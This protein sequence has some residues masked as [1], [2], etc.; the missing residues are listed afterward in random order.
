MG[1]GL[2]KVNVVFEGDGY[3]LI[4][5][6]EHGYIRVD[7]LPSM[8]ELREYYSKQYFSKTKPGFTEDQ[9]EEIDWYKLWFEEFRFHF[10]RLLMGTGTCPPKLLEIGC[11]NGLMLLHF[12]K[13]GW[14]VAGIEPSQDISTFAARKNIRI[15]NRL[16]EEITPNDI[17][18]FDCIM[19]SGVL[20]HIRDPFNIINRC[21]LFLKKD[22]VLCVRVPNDFNPFQMA[23]IKKF[24][25]EQWWICIPDHL[26]YFNVDTLERLIEKAGYNILYRTTSFPMELFLLFG[27]IYIN[28][29]KLGKDCHRERMK[30]EL[31]LLETGNIEAMRA[32]YEELAKAKLGREIIVF[33]RQPKKTFC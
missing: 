28:D 3:R 19:L 26:N 24:N 29:P 16:I 15:E 31:P 17:G 6:P 25:L 20:E 32:M 22:G 30:M 21:T 11:G 8:N 10:D 27:R 18:H 12:S 7:P 9:L 14:E 4:E 1:F 13:F 33:A 5:D 2:Q 23:A